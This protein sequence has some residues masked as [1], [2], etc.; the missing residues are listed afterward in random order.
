MLFTLDRTEDDRIAVMI[1]DDGEKKDVPFSLITG[2]I[3]E[4]N[5]Y[6]CENGSFIYNEKETEKRKNINREKFNKLL[7]RAKN[8]K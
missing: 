4:G 6:S 3:K 5:V 8:R 2:G 1:S 7:K